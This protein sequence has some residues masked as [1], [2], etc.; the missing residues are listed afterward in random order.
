MAVNKVEI[1]TPEGKHTLIDLTGDTVTP[2]TLAKGAT[3]HDASGDIIT[4]TMRSV[5]EV[6][7]TV[8]VNNTLL[9][10]GD[11][12]GKTVFDMTGDGSYTYYPVSEQVLSLDDLANGLILESSGISES[13]SEEIKLTDFAK[14]TNKIIASK[15]VSSVL[16]VLEDNASLYGKVIPKKGVYFMRS[17]AFDFYVSRIKIEGYTGFNSEVQVIKKKY[18]P[19]HP[20]SFGDITGA[21]TLGVHTDGKVY[22]FI[23]GSPVGDGIALVNAKFD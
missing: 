6:L 15:S 19:E 4:G 1:N 2:E 5:D 18:I 8:T 12:E 23:D 21:I 16:F 22:I 10:D 7:E 17:E 11:T 3:A 14:M 20:H 9:W 13:A